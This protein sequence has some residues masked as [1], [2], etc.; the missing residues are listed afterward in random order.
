MIVISPAIIKCILI[1]IKTSRAPIKPLRGLCNI[2]WYNSTPAPHSHFPNRLSAIKNYPSIRPWKNHTSLQTTLSSMTVLHLPSTI[3][4]SL[5][6]K[7]LIS[8]WTGIKKSIMIQA[9]QAQPWEKSFLLQID[10]S[11]SWKTLPKNSSKLLLKTVKEM[12]LTW[13]K[14]S[15]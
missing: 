10:H 15:F 7:T 1:L 5:S 12:A 4:P 14:I 13:K 9:P 8:N 3:M 2:P 6:S 11:L